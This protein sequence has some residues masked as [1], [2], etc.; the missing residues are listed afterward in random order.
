[1]GLGDSRP[2]IGIPAQRQV[3]NLAGPGAEFVLRERYVRAVAD[4][5]AAPVIVPLLAGE[6]ALR[7]V[8]NLLNGLLLP[9]G[10]DVA[11]ER[12]GQKRHRGLGRVRH[13]QDRV[14]ITLA[15]WALR[16]D[17]PVLAI[18]RGLQVLNVAAG[19]SLFQ[20]IR[21][22]LPGSLDH[23]ARDG[24]PKSEISHFVDVVA[25][26]RLAA[27]LGAERLGVNSRHHQAVDRLAEGFA[28]SA[29]AGDGVVEGMEHASHRFSVGVQF[30]PEDLYQTQPRL[31]ALFAGFVAA[32]RG[33]RG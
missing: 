29:T 9:G 13:D 16:D 19:G 21:S 33:G 7:E 11:P 25:G 5:G 15:G 18:C 14:E 4:A 27:L 12:Y 24:S 23:T 31:A 8:Y 22:Q 2:L 20:D 6:A 1:M 28:V 3:A 32:C 17:L 10:G 26:T 30:H